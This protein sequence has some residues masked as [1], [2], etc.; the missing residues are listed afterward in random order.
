MVLLYLSEAFAAARL[1][2]RPQSHG[3]W[4]PIGVF[5]FSIVLCLWHGVKRIREYWGRARKVAV[6]ASVLD[7]VILTWTPKDRFTLRDLLNGGIAILGRTGSGK[8]SSSGYMLGKGMVGMPSSGGLILASSLDDRAFWERVFALAGRSTDLLVFEP[9][10]PLQFNLIDYEMQNGADARELTQCFLTIDETLKRRKKGGDGKNEAFWEGGKERLFYNA[11]VLIRLATGKLGAPELA[12]FINGAATKPEQL[13][14]EQWRKGAHCQCLQQAMAAAKSQVDEFDANQA[15]DFW[16]GQWPAMDP[17]VR[18]NLLTDAMNVLHTLCSGEIRILL[19]SGTSVSPATLEQ[20]KWVLV[21]MPVH[22]KGAGGL[23]VNAAWKYAVQRHV[24]RRQAA[25]ETAPIVIWCDEY[26]NVANSFDSAFLAECRKHRGAMV[27]LT[28]NIH[29]FHTATKDDSQGHHTKAL[30]GNFSVKVFHALADSETAVFG[31]DLI[32]KD[33][34]V[35]IGGNVSGAGNLFEQ[36]MGKSEFSGSFSERYEPIVQPRVFLSGLRT[37]GPAND[38]E[39][40]AIVVK[41][42]EPFANGQ[43]WLTVTFSQK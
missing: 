36:L 26:Q 40:D 18:S 24:L 3:Y 25:E 13:R 30:L 34:E 31:S 21:N 1:P 41:S 27:V 5:G 29:S 16:L 9:G 8:T 11:I 19:S 10:G 38:F 7:W 2:V 33:K 37:G 12:E 15:I 6:A 43:S 17:E 35:F 22:N 42:G 4:L 28:Q 39:C 32:Q 23:A 20:G 14:D